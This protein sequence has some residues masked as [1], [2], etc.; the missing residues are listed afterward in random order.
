[1]QN[2]K[3]QLITGVLFVIGGLLALFNPLAASLSVELL[4]G[5]FFLVVGCIQ[6]FGAWRADDW[7]GRLWLI[8]MGVVAIVL[9]IN[10]LGQP[11]S[12]LIALTIVAGI[13]FLVSAIVKIIV[14]L[15]VAMTELKIAV[16]L[17]G[18]VSGVL[19]FMILSNIP[20]SAVVTLGILMGV[21]LLSTGVATIA[22]AMARK[23]GGV[24]H[25]G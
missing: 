9:G 1:M 17:S 7:G 3:I 5:W 14:G 16:V 21:E 10:L 6:L 23:S 12:G 20:G 24:S 4:A 25:S 19:G 13:L 11:L 18:I 8:L 2:W 15:R 22:L